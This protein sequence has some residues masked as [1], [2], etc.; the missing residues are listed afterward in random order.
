MWASRSST[1]HRSGNGPT[2]CSHTPNRRIARGIVDPSCVHPTTSGDSSDDLPQCPDD[3]VAV[4]GA[5]TGVGRQAEMCPAVP[6]RTGKIPPHKRGEGTL[7]MAGNPV[8][9]SAKRHSVVVE[10]AQ[11]DVLGVEA[12]GEDHVFVAVVTLRCG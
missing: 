4:V 2:G 1:W 10:H 7:A 9:E 6:V 5:H 8:N 12:V 11:T 3:V